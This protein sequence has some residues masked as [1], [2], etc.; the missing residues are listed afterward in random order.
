MP[1]VLS[2]ISRSATESAATIKQE[3]VDGKRNERNKRKKK[4]DD[5]EENSDG[6]GE[7]TTD[8]EVSDTEEIDAH[9]ERTK[10]GQTSDSHDGSAETDD[11]LP[12]KVTYSALSV[13]ELLPTDKVQGAG[14]SLHAVMMQQKRKLW[15]SV[16]QLALHAHPWVRLS[17]S[18]LMGSEFSWLQSHFGPTTLPFG[19][20]GVL[21]NVHDLVH[22][23]NM[24]GSQLQSPYLNAALG[25]QIIKNLLFL[26][27]AMWLQEQTGATSAVTSAATPSTNAEKKYSKKIATKPE[28]QAPERDQEGER[29]GEKG[30][31]ITAPIYAEGS[32]QEAAQQGISWIF[33][34]VSVTLRSKLRKREA[35]EVLLKLLAVL[36]LKLD[37]QCVQQQLSNVL[38][39]LFVVTSTLSRE[40]DKDDSVFLCSLASQVLQSI[41]SHLGDA[42]VLSAYDKIRQQI[43]SVRRKRKLAKKMEAVIDPEAF[44]RK[45]TIKNEKKRQKR[46]DSIQQFK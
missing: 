34:T 1:N 16:Q 18:R 10:N 23:T 46:K 2:I 39:P 43:H 25:E 29:E 36:A 6:E 45:K 30:G 41:Q 27:R 38:R 37:K 14:L 22:L 21:A 9:G 12:W 11:G 3:A 31:M 26:C 28:Q 40:T 24:S 17:A 13:L 33:S 42:L 8:E 20:E 4:Q 19:A 5:E 15:M 7:Q 32:V 44:A 35:C